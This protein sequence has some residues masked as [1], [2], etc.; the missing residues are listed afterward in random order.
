[1]EDNQALDWDAI[2]HGEDVHEAA[3]LARSTLSNP[4]LPDITD[5]TRSGAGRGWVALSIEKLDR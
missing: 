2:V 4:E 5:P 1:M 3:T